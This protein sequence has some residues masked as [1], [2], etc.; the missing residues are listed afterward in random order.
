MASLKRSYTKTA[1]LSLSAKI[2]ERLEGA[3]LFLR[4]SCVAIYHAL[5]GE[6]QTAGFIEKW[7]QEKRLLLPVVKGDDLQLR[8]YSGKESVTAGAFGIPEPTE[9]CPVVPEDEI[10][11][12]LVPGVAFDR[13]CNRL[14]RGKGFYDRLLS[15]LNIP[16]IGICYDFQLRDSIP[17]EPFDRKMDLIVTES[18]FIGSQY[19]L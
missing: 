6:V 18:A 8:L 12:I 9:A 4:A 11:L 14:G 1:L 2:M 7:Y 19:P 10:D 16:K 15:T 5:P 17:V 13:R 3:D